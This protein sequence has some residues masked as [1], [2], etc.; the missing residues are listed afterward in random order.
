M[1]RLLHEP[2]SRTTARRIENVVSGLILTLALIAFLFLFFWMFI[3]SFKPNLLITR[4]PPAW[5]FSPT[6]EHYVQVFRQNPFLV[7][8][9]NSLIIALS[10][11]GVSLAIGLPAAYSIVKYKQGPLALALLVI[12][13]LPGIS[14]MIPLFILYKRLGLLDTHPGIIVTHVLTVLPLITWVMLGFFEDVPGEL[15]DAALID[16]CSQ[17]GA[18]TRVVIPL[19]VPGI[20]AAAILSYIASWNNFIFVLILGGPKTMTLPL[21]VYGFLAYGQVDWGALSAAA[22]IVTVPVLILALAVQRYLAGGLTMGAVK[23]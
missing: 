9:S 4:Y 18:F 5:A 3:S 14:F 13:M 10:S 15:E 12:R 2:M 7:Y 1:K 23:G 16:G 11:V 6:L 20:T 19:S 21:A 22:T 17:L 8:M